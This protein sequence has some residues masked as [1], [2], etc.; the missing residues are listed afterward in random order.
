MKVLDGRAIARKIIND[1][2][3]KPGNWR[4][5]FLGALLIGN[6]R[7]S[8][9]FLE[10]KEKI[11]RELGIDFRLYQ[12]SM[13]L[14]TDELRRKIGKLAQPKT[15]GGFIIQLPLPD[16]ANKHYVLNAVPKEKD[17]DVLSEKG[18]G[19][20][21]TGRGKVMPP[22]VGVVKEILEGLGW[23][24]RDLSVVLV[25]AGFLI[26]RPVGFWL[27]NRVGKLTI[28]DSSTPDF[29]SKLNEADVVISGVGKPDLFSADDLKD[30]ALVIDF[31]F[32]LKQGKIIG[33]FQSTG[34]GGGNITYT[35]TP[36]G[37]GPILVAKL[38]ENFLILNS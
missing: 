15:C 12:V 33:D 11:A 5:K 1:L 10:Q 38:Y 24:L 19:A 23:K 27:Q 18:L 37:T 14:T 3:E 22:S 35:K 21:Y 9:N 16:K 30:N 31:G 36:G 28:F 17:V 26:G 32:N 25:G 29:R 20:F 7:A 8:L 34:M 2:K 4:D 6:D 13:D